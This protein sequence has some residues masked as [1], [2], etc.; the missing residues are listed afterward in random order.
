MS[1]N[2]DGQVAIVTGAS[3]GVG[4]AVARLLAAR[5][6]RTALV[7][8]SRDKLET[9]EA[10]LGPG[11]LAVQTDLAIPDEVD[12]M[13][14]TVRERLGPIDI[15]H[16]NAG[17]FMTGPAIDENPDDWD[18][19]LA[20]NVNSVFRA[21]HRVLPDMIERRTG[22][23]IVTSSIAGH[24]MMQMEPVYSA[25][26]HA[27]QAFVRAIRAQTAKHNIRVGAIAPGTVLNELWG[28]TE[29]AE[30]DRRVAEHSGITSE[31]VAEA[32]LFMLTRPDHV[33]IRDMVMLPQ[34]Q[35]I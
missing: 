21:V 9:L 5:R 6:V 13:V 34:G 33:T 25:S 15:L 24:R 29:Q 7:A 12:R 10:E 17:L 31:D 32:V 1:R 11:C 8:R 26:K 2:L 18:K 16:A 4:R 14:A 35:E 27:V 19:L 22:D 30:I 3:S 23:I 20:V 28:I